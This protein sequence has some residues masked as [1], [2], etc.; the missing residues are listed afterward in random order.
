M[1]DELSINFKTVV[2]LSDSLLPTK[3]NLLR[4]SAS[5]FDPLCL[6]SAVTVQF[7]ILR[8]DICKLHLGWGTPLP[9]NL[10]KILYELIEDLKHGRV[11]SIPRCYFS[12]VIDEAESYTLH[13]FGDA[14]EKAFSTII[15]VVMK[16]HSAC[17]PRLI[18]SKSKDHPH[19]TTYNSSHGVVG[20][21]DIS[22][23]IEYCKAGS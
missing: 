2:T 20:Y 15:Y 4:L 21:P 13:M 12:E 16:V 22:K 3:S 5:I 14:S 19:E 11:I 6:I 9:Q 10:A 23:V 8:Q 18:A 17:H 7:R 1:E